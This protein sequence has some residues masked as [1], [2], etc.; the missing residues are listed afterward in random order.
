[1]SMLT[2]SAPARPVVLAALFA[3]GLSFSPAEAQGPVGSFRDGVL[4]PGGR[5]VG[6]TYGDWQASFWQWGLSM[7]TT[8]SPLYDTAPCDAGQSGPVWFLGG[9]FGSTITTPTG[10]HEIIRERQCE[11]PAGKILYVA[12]ANAEASDLEGN[13][14]TLRE[15]SASARGVAAAIDPASLVLTID[16]RAVPNLANFYAESPLYRFKLATHNN[17]LSDLGAPGNIDGAYGRSVAAGYGVLVAPLSP[18]RHTIHLEADFPE[19]QFR[20]NITYHLHVSSPRR[21]SS[22]GVL[23][24]PSPASRVTRAT[25]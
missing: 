2:T 15:L 20:L 14:T 9:G 25:R 3:L 18:G 5:V 21:A 19:F 11:I 23:G 1:M 22:A 12:V 8:A 24:Q 17:V 4:P 6:R 7:P 16:G 13:G 10:E